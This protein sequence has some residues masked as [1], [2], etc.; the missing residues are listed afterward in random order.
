MWTILSSRPNVWYITFSLGPLFTYLNRCILRHFNNTCAMLVSDNRYLS[1]PLQD[2]L[3]KWGTAQTFT[4]NRMNPT[5]TFQSGNAC[6]FMWGRFL[7]M[8]W[9]LLKCHFVSSRMLS[10]PFAR[11]WGFALQSPLITRNGYGTIIFTESGRIRSTMVLSYL[12]LFVRLAADLEM[13]IS[14]IMQLCCL[15]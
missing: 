2:L 4:G 7:G 12:T 8:A 9:T 3:S 1:R 14:I 10:I 6:N 13:S 11:P 15:A 5:H